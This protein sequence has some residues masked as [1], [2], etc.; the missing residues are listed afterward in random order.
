MTPEDTALYLADPDFALSLGIE[1]PLCSLCGAPV[2]SPPLDWD[3]A[4]KL[5]H[6]I[7]KYGCSNAH[8]EDDKP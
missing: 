3:G 1:P 8:P 5:R 7:P 4:T 6:L 2:R